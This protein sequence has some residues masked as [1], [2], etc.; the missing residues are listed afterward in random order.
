MDYSVDVLYLLYHWEISL[1]EA[2]RIY[3]NIWEMINRGEIP[4]D[5]ANALCLS[6]YEATAFAHGAGLEDLV[7]LRFEGWPTNCSRCGLPVDYKDYGWWY[8]EDAS[9]NPSLHHIECS[10]MPQ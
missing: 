5:W 3:D 9:G 1:E 2:Y 7:K 8:V 6:E 4:R 10:V